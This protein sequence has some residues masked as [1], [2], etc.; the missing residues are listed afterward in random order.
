MLLHLD[1]DLGGNPDDACALAMLLGWP[2]LDL[3]A[4]TTTM[5]PGGRRAGCV[6]H[7]LGLAGGA[8]VQVVAG[9]AM[10]STVR[11]LAAPT[12]Q[13]PRYWPADLVARPW[14]AGAA[15]DCLERSIGRGAVITAIG[16]LTNLAALELLRPGALS[17][18]EVVA[19][20][21][22]VDPPG[23]GLPAWGP[24]RDFNIAWDTR[25]AATVFAAA[26]SLTLVTLPATLSAHV[27]GGD[28]PRLRALGPMGA[29]LARQ[30]QARAEDT[31]TAEL[32]RSHRGLPD[33]L[34]TFQFD[35]V[36]CAAAVRWRGVRSEAMRLSTDLENGVLAFRRDPYGR[37]V[38]VVTDVD[39]A[40][41]A[42]TWFAALA[43]AAR[44]S[45]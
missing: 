16:P 43:R 31:G 37:E 45:R 26:G 38:R 30:I 12:D 5:D 20:G 41:F 44:A 18:A 6:E 13:D 1:T 15:L 29:L 36:T 9:A 25:A 4:I 39:A 33:D 17:G 24:A 32:A 22:W 7:V 27:R 2:D 34:L 23:P 14:S 35:P 11:E 21:G 10:S 40:A 42:D 8:G 3:A 28:L 19:M